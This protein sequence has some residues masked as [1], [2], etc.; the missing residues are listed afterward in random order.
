MR[1]DDHGTDVSFTELTGIDIGTLDHLGE[2][3][4][5]EHFRQLALRASPG[6]LRSALEM[7]PGGTD[8]G[9]EEHDRLASAYAD[10]RTGTTMGLRTLRDLF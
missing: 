6:Q 8:D 3:E 10:R 2:P 1:E 4:L 9:P 5:R 7:K